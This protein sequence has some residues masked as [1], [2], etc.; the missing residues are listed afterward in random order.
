MKYLTPLTMILAL[1]L[2]FAACSPEEPSPYSGAEVGDTIQLGGIDWL[3]LDVQENRALLISEK[4]LFQRQWHYEQRLL[5]WEPSDMRQYLNGAFFDRTF[6]EEEKAYIL[7]TTVVNNM[8]PWFGT[9]GVGADTT[10]R[11]FLLSLEEVVQYFGDSGMLSELAGLPAGEISIPITDD[12][13]DARIAAPLESDIVSWWWLRT[14]GRAVN[15]L[16]DASA[17]AITGTGDIIVYGI[18]LVTEGGVRPAL[19]LRV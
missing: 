10:D 17:A 4:V 8:N 6:S 7:E 9:A 19:W 18:Y 5:T 14:P 16:V 2:F 3:V 11:V 13:N 12:Y 15:S 1:A